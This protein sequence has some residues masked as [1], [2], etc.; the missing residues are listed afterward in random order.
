MAPLR[1]STVSKGAWWLIH[2]HLQF[3]AHAA[4]P[5][6]G[7]R[8]HCRRLQAADPEQVVR[9]AD[10]PRRVLR[11]GEAAE[12]GLAQAANGLE[13]AEDF[14]D[15]LAAALTEPIARVARGAAI[16]PGCVPPGNL[17]KVRTNPATAQSDHFNA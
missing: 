11:L 15:L 8:G 3:T 6:R 12:A 9:R 5:S 4:V 14:F 16:Q 10:K 7:S 17:G 13:P 1:I 2:P